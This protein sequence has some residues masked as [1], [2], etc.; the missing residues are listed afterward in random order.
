MKKFLFTIIIQVVFVYCLIAQNIG[1]G[2]N[3]PQAKLHIK[4][5]ADT[6]QLVIDANSTQ[7]NTH[8]LIRLRSAAGVDLVHIHSDHTTNTF[9]GLNSGRVNNA[10]GGALGNTFIG[11][12]SGASNLTGASLTGIGTYSLLNN[13]AGKENTAVGPSTLYYNTFGSYNTA[14][15]RGALFQN[16]NTDNNTAIG[17]KSLFSNIGV[18]NTAIGSQSLI[19]NT[20]GQ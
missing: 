7:L 9:L 12:Q 16:I 14:M 15:G 10:G 6:S 20:N 19:S 3:T 4:G 11:S 17:F 8:P 1:I 13:I 18:N 2:I 5:S